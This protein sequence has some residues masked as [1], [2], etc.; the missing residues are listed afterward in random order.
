MTP[1]RLGATVLYVTDVA[2]SVEFYRRALGLE[3]RFYDEATG[4]AE[5]GPEGFIAVASHEAGEMMMPG[6]YPNPRSGRPSGVEIAFYTD[7]VPA[8]F[9]RAVEAGGAPLTEPRLMPWGQMVAYVQSV[10][11]TILGL[12]TPPAAQDTF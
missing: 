8:A 3:P 6:A 5:L 10:D 11:G 9:R 4:F 1:L 12:L 7:D 2:A